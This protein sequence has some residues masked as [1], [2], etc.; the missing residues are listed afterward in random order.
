MT[1]AEKPKRL[2][3]VWYVRDLNAV[4]Y[5]DNTVLAEFLG[6]TEPEARAAAQAYVDTLLEH[7]RGGGE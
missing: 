4:V 3:I 7:F 1:Q 5:L 6:D 2:S